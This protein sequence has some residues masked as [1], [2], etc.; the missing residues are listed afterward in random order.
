MLRFAPSPTSDMSIGDMRIA[1]IN[2]VVARRRGEQFV[3]RIEDMD[4]E[5]NIEGKDQEIQD[6]LKKFAIEQDQL[7]YQSDNLGRHQQF[8][9]SLLESGGAFACICMEQELA[10]S[11]EYPHKCSGG[12]AQNSTE[13]LAEIKEHNTPY[14]VRIK[15]PDEAIVFVD[16][17]RGEIATEIDDFVILRADGTPTSDLAVACDDMMSGISI[18]IR[19]EDHLSSTPRQIQIRDSLGYHGDMEYAHIPTILDESG[20]QMGGEMG[21]IRW[22][23]QQGFLLDTIINYLLLIGNQTPQELFTLPDAMQW[24]ELES[25]CADQVRFDIEKLR[26]LNREHLSNMDE[27]SLSAIFGFADADI[28][29]LLKLYLEE[30]STINEL[31]TKIKALFAPKDCRTECGDEMRTIAEIIRDAPMISSFDDFKQHIIT[32]SGLS[33]EMILEPLQRL[34]GGAGGKQKLAD[35]YPLIEPYITEIARCES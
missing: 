33:E 21:T 17:I 23:L 28:G 8:A 29:R 26:S 2:Y 1:L 15:K 19:S 4:K 22:M 9:I 14:V 32:H 24:L 13:I 27:K 16:K 3:L 34:M 6:I 18:V 31:D 30:A 10:K 5:H 12:C 7:F 35:V 11:S 25:I 20:E